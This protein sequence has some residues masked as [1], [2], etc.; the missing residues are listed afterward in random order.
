LVRFVELPNLRNTAWPT[1]GCTQTERSPEAGFLCYSELKRKLVWGR[2]E[3]GLP[4]EKSLIEET[5]SSKKQAKKFKKLINL[6]NFFSKTLLWLQES[7][8]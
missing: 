8:W 1:I 7:E 3:F 5:T 2:G 4:P 6:S